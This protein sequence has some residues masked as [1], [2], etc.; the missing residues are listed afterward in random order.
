MENV[1]ALMAQMSHSV[2]ASDGWQILIVFNRSKFGCSY[3]CFR[4]TG[5]NYLVN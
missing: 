2:S 4:N 3:L 1:I 5:I